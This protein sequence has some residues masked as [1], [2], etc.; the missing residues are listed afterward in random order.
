MS[1]EGA[2]GRALIFPGDRE[3]ILTEGRPE[4]TPEEIKIAPGRFFQPVPGGGSG[5]ASGGASGSGLRKESPEG[6]SG[7]EGASS[8][9]HAR[10]DSNPESHV[11]I[12][13]ATMILIVFLSI[14]CDSP[15]V[16]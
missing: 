5:R 7:R 3:G 2:S 4:E 15:C 9:V 14:F 13:G 12:H 6:D 16:L 1:P 10:T 8:P 11:S